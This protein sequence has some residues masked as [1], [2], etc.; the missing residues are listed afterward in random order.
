MLDRV[1]GYGW[2][3][4]VKEEI[5]MDRKVKEEIWMDRPSYPFPTQRLIHVVF[6]FPI[7]NFFHRES[8]NFS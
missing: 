7:Y 4:K 8:M 2:I 6:N 1:K 3:R 5:W